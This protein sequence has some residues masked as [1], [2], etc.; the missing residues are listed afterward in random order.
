MLDPPLAAF[1]DVSFLL[2]HFAY[3]FYF[4]LCKSCLYVRRCSIM[5]FAAGFLIKSI[6]I[7]NVSFSKGA[8]MNDS[9]SVRGHKGRQ[10]IYPAFH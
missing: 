2:Q 8:N 5:L 7:E 9:S 6:S 4:S 10:L 1:I 3:L